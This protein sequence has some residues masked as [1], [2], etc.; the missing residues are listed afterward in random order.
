MQLNH[1]DRCAQ[2]PGEVL[3]LLVPS[4]TPE[5][6]GEAGPAGTYVPEEVPGPEEGE[7]ASLQTVLRFGPRRVN[8]RPGKASVENEAVI[9]D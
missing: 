4:Y 6:A 2:H 7:A 3:K 1:C 9:V 8:D 5:A